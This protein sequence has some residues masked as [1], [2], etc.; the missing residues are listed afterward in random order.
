MRE[1]IDVELA[2]TESDWKSYFDFIRIRWPDGAGKRRIRT[3]GI[4]LK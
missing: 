1:G 3:N 2:V 4:Y